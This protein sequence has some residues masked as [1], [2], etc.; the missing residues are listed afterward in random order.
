MC[1]IR[2]QERC[3]I[4]IVLRPRAA[5][6]QS[7]DQRVFYAEALQGLGYS[8]MKPEQLQVNTQ[9]LARTVHSNHPWRQTADDKNSRWPFDRQHQVKHCWQAC[10]T[11][12]LAK[13]HQQNGE[14]IPSRNDARLACQ[15]LCITLCNNYIPQCII[16]FP[17]ENSK[18]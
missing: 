4:F 13:A 3:Q 18:Y 16:A 6:D 17:M 14:N 2:L 7:M 8:T 11:Q 15:K 1:P 9:Q 12:A 10:R 5:A